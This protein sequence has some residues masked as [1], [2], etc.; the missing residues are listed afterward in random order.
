LG[1]L[2]LARLAFGAV[3]FTWLMW[4]DIWQW[5][6]MMKKGRPE[7]PGEPSEEPGATLQVFTPVGQTILTLLVVQRSDSAQPLRHVS[8][9]KR[10][11]HSMLSMKASGILTESAESFLR[12][13]HGTPGERK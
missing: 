10:R 8:H 1:N 2:T 5:G 11:R 4:C 3:I 12:K 6:D 7:L 13:V 9:V